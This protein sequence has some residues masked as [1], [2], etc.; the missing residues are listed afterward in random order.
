MKCQNLLSGKNKKNILRCCLLKILSRVPSINL[1][2]LVWSLTGLD[3]TIKVMS[4]QSVYLTTLFLGRLSSKQITSTKY[5]GEVILSRENTPS[6]SLPS[7]WKK[8]IFPCEQIL[9]KFVS[10][11]KNCRISPRCNQHLKKSCKGSK[12]HHQCMTYLS[13]CVLRFWSFL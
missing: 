7:F 2:W 10:L 12:L 11:V 1:I 3:N 8:G 4:S 5:S 6:K 13:F 9:S